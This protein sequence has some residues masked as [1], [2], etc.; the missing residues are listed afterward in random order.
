MINYAAYFFLSLALSMMLIEW[1][2]VGLATQ[3]LILKSLSY[4]VKRKSFL[5]KALLIVMPLKFLLGLLTSVFYCTSDLKLKFY[6]F[7][8]GI[9][10]AEMGILFI[11]N[12]KTLVN[13]IRLNYQEYFGSDLLFMQIALILSSIS[14]LLRSTYQITSFV[15]FEDG[16]MEVEQRIDK[17]ENK[18]V[19][20]G[21]TLGIV[22]LTEI[23]P[24][25]SLIITNAFILKQKSMKMKTIGEQENEMLERSGQ[26]SIDDRDSFENSLT[27][28][29]VRSIRTLIINEFIDK[30]LDNSQYNY[31][32]KDKSAGREIFWT[33]HF[34]EY[35]DDY[36]DK[37]T[38]SEIAQDNA[39]FNEKPMDATVGFMAMTEN[40]KKRRVSSRRKRKRLTT[41]KGKIQFILSS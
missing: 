5:L 19:M 15:F 1:T 24:I 30:D 9:F 36:I 21:L 33:Y 6:A 3:S 40:E 27:R 37:N 16:I 4:Y 26:S 17:L 39:N 22:F 35:I 12:A 29:Q 13:N 2:K 38:K 11:I 8:D 20:L 25:A 10:L 7:F 28:S 34:F 32:M 18:L 14:Y 41:H 23:L 31:Q